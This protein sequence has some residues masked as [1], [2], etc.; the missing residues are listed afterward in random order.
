MQ[1][2]EA[3]RRWRETW[4]RCWP[5]RDV[6]PISAL[7]AEGAT[8]HSHPFREP[9]DGGALGYVTRAFAQE[10]AGT[11]CWFG[12]PMVDG[13]RA[14][15]EYWAQL[16]DVEDGASTLAG[17]SVLRFDHSGLVIEHFDYWVMEPGTI[18]PPAGWGRPS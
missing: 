3:A 12:A 8:Y 16:Q 11:R 6:S 9:E 14:A 13:D 18:G 4:L 17:V 2:G 5:I 1:S 7:Y 10:T 15:I